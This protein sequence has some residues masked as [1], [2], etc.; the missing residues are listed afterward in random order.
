LLG[1]DPD[2]HAELAFS[3]QN[4]SAMFQLLL[5][6]PYLTVMVGMSGKGAFTNSALPRHP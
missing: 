2:P 3:R 6:L 1:G 5:Y 4:D